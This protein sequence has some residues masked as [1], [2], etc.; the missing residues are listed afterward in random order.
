MDFIQNFLT[1]DKNKIEVNEKKNNKRKRMKNEEVVEEKESLVPEKDVKRQIR[2]IKNRESA[3]ASRERRKT[4]VKG[5]EDTV[6]NLNT[7]KTL[8]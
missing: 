3:Q 4:Y 7:K 5:L 6:K 8:H 1:N 2:L